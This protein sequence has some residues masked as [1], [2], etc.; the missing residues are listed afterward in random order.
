MWPTW[1]R[2]HVAGQTGS[3]PGRAT[4][5]IEEFVG[6][7]EAGGFRGSYDVEIFS[8]DG[9]FGRRFPDSLWELPDED[10]VARA[11]ALLRKLLSG[12]CSVTGTPPEGAHRTED[13][14]EEGR[15]H[16]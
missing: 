6:V 13:L 2:L 14:R 8:D 10:C 12:M 9:T 15:H 3:S 11:T 16:V 5:P 7:L 1:S 4:L